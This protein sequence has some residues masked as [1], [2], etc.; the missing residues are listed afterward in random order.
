MFRI[1]DKIKPRFG[2]PAYEH[3]APGTILTVNIKHDPKNKKS[4][5]YDEPDGHENGWSIDYFELA[6]FPVEPGDELSYL[7]AFQF[8]FRD[9]V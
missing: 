1:G 4:V 3:Y 2:S 7:N 9:G 8:N 6:K 5:S